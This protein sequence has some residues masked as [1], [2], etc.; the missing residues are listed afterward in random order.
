MNPQQQNPARTDELID[1]VKRIKDRI[2]SDHHIGRNET[3]TRNSLIN[4]ILKTLGWD[5]EDSKLVI[6]EYQVKSGV[7]DY[8]LLG[9]RGDP[10]DVLVFIEAKRM[11]EELDSSHRKQLFRYANSR[12]DVKYAVLTNGDRWDFF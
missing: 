1:A 5:P 10:R 2:E 12:R 11:A 7:V 3:R 6:P 4:P 8:A 9:T